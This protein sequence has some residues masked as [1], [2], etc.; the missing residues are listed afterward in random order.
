MVNDTARRVLVTGA[1]GRLGSVVA[2][3]FHRAGFDVVAT[4][5][6]ET[7]ATPY[8]FVQADLLDHNAAL[9]L[10]ADTQIVLHIGNIPGIGATPC[11]VVFNHNV[12]I[13]QNV[14]QGAAERDVEKIVFASTLQLVGS[15]VDDRTVVNPPPP[16][17]YPMHGATE[18]NPANVYALSKT[19]SETMLRYYAE[20]C[21]IDCVAL[22]FP[23]LHPHGQLALVATGEESPVDVVE[24]FTSLSYDDAA[25]LFGAVVEREL[26]GY[27]CLMAGSSRRHRDLAFPELLAAHYPQLDGALSDLIDE[28]P[29]TAATGWRSSYPDRGAK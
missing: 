1:A 26:R 9:D 28:S 16:P 6:V 8:P 4:D 5:I 3:R 11:Q 15:W 14:F 13:N 27:H 2:D 19:V 18:P 17:A 10:L 23:L 21:G 22:R 7:A 29:V 24:G 20:R 12:T 25:A